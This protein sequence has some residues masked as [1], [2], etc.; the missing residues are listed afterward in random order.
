VRLRLQENPR[1][2]GGIPRSDPAIVLG[3]GELCD[4]V[5]RPLER[6]EL[7]LERVVGVRSE[8][9]DAVAHGEGR[10]VL[11][12]DS[13]GH[14]GKLGTVIL[15]MRRYRRCERWC[16]L[17]KDKL[18]TRA[19]RRLTANWCGVRMSPRLVG[20]SVG[21]SCTSTARQVF[22]FGAYR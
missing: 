14:A 17:M 5:T 4:G 2:H 1:S 6:R 19:R 22:D 16:R 7:E 8:T 9:L 10:E 15:A 18:D 3:K 13:G 12:G 11:R 21:L 20:R